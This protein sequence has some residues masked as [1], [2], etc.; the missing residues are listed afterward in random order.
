MSYWHKLQKPYTG[1]HWWYR[2]LTG[3][4]WSY[5]F[6]KTPDARY[7]YWK[8]KKVNGAD[9]E[10]ECKILNLGGKLRN[11]W[12]AFRNTARKAIKKS[13]KVFIDYHEKRKWIK[14]VR[15][16]G[17]SKGWENPNKEIKGETIIWT[18]K[19]I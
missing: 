4:K 7:C 2:V 19:I 16:I 8:H 15:E 6:M 3:R 10:V 11:W 13:L 9:V 1:S 5:P 18:P 12:Y 17:W 14:L